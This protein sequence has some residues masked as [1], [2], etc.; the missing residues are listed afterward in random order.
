[1][2]PKVHFISSIHI[3]ICQNNVQY[4][5]NFVTLNCLCTA[6]LYGTHTHAQYTKKRHVCYRLLRFVQHFVFASQ[7]ALKHQSAATCLPGFAG[8]NPADGMYISVLWLLYVFRQLSLWPS[9]TSSRGVLPSVFMFFVTDIYRP[10]GT[11]LCICLLLLICTL[12]IAP[13]PVC[14]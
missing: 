1:M 5:N 6:A 12:L 4:R 2:K 10:H 8:S 9:D 7:V 3:Y 14:L 11:E 13:Q